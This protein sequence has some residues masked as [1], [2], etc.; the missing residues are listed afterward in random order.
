MPRTGGKE[1]AGPFDEGRG[2]KSKS[3]KAVE[4]AM[5]GQMQ[6]E[7]IASLEVQCEAAKERGDEEAKAFYDAMLKD[8]REHIPK[9]TGLPALSDEDQKDAGTWLKDQV[10]WVHRTGETP[11]EFLVRMYRNPLV[12]MEDRIKAALGARDLVHP[13]V[14]STNF[15]K[16]KGNGDNDAR[17]AD[18]RT[19]L[20]ERLSGLARASTHDSA[21]DGAGAKPRPAADRR[22]G[23]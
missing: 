8:I 17:N 23:T 13:K 21:K 9:E 6:A 15:L 10:N 2:G 1:P 20:A 5:R 7:E 19:K 14:P 3:K 22:R 18:I 11:M 16:E 12:S 4:A